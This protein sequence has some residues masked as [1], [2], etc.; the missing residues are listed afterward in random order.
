MSGPLALDG[1]RILDLSRVL[2]GPF[3]GALL[4]DMGADV[5]KVEDTRGGDE[6]RT[7]PP[8]KQGEAAAYLVNNRNKRGIAL[9]LKSREGVEVMRRLIEP[10]DVLVENF[11]TGTMESFGLGYDALAA[12]QPRLVYC[13]I[14]AFGRTGP[15]AES[16]GYEAV[17]QAFSGVMSIT[18][19]PG[20]A[21]DRCGVS[22]LDLG[23]GALAAFGIVN[24]LLQREATGRGQ[25]VDASLLATAVS[26]LNYHAE[27][28][29]IAGV[30]P[31]PLGSSHPSIVP[32]RNFRCRDGRWV[33][34]AGAN[35]RLWQ[36]LAAAIGL[37]HLVADPRFA[38]NPDRVKH[39]AALEAE[40]EAAIAR[41]D[42]DPLLTMLA[43]AD[44]PAVPVNTV[45]RVLTDAQTTALDMVERVRH[46]TLGEL[47]M[48][49]FPLRFSAMSAGVRR[50]PPR[51]GEHTDEILAEHG[52]T[53]AEIA[54]LRA[55]KAVA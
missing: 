18:G 22:F 14:A 49:G 2:A 26:L 13:S 36:R 41:Y 34:I 27:G 32:Y 40:V 29:L 8:L 23:T 51:L 21:P 19:E 1:I 17:M 37:D 55:R 12:T 43:E 42:A 48:V 6:A 25:R 30:V 47:P 54:A 50:P 10:A 9:D 3:C 53:A 5:I 35:D 7:W 45:D 11:R 31:G 39:R 44:V 24:A 38:G 20:G 4:G 28:Y 46:P 52:Y 16:G 33:F 15:R